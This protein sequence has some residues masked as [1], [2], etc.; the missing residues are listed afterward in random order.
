MVDNLD[1][2]YEAIS[3]S[4][5]MNDKPTYAQLVTAMRGCIFL[6]ANPPKYLIRRRTGYERVSSAELKK[7]LKAMGDVTYTKDITSTMDKILRKIED[8]L[9]LSTFGQETIS[10]VND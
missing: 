4:Q 7:I 3:A 1:S 6:C 5:V 10:I 2:I 9:I 8:S